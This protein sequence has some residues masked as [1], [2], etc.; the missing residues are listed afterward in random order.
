RLSPSTLPGI[1][2]YNDGIPTSYYQVFERQAPVQIY[3]GKPA[4]MVWGFNVPTI[5]PGG[6]TYLGPTFVAK[7]GERVVIRMNN[8]LGPNN[9]SIRSEEHTS[10][11]Q[12][13]E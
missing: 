1:P 11:L 13:R 6:Q 12:S 3:P 10:E 8:N 5:T 2:I 9:D 4:T 7:I